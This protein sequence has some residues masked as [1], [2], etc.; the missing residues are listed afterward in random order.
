MRAKFFDYRREHK[1][2]ACDWPGE[3][4][5]SDRGIHEIKC[6]DVGRQGIGFSSPIPLD[7]DSQAQIKVDIPESGLLVLEG[8]ICWCEKAETGWKLGVALNRVLPRPL[9]IIL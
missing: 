2:L 3:I 7:V 4:A 1:R 9:E 6:A 8:R 5:T